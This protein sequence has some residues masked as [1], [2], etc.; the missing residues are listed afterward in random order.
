MRAGSHGRAHGVFARCAREQRKRACTKERNGVRARC[1]Y[2]QRERA[3]TE[4]RIACSCAART[5]SASGLVRKSG[6]ACSHAARASS[7]SGFA[8]NRNCSAPY[9]RRS[10]SALGWGTRIAPR[11]IGALRAFGLA[12]ANE[13]GSSCALVNWKSIEV[14]YRG[15][16]GAG[17]ILVPW[18]KRRRPAGWRAFSRF[19]WG[20]R[21]RT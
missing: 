20:T 21:I 3:W 7:A 16:S 13:F 4:E 14:A 11:A 6:T 19:G 10:G 2:E 15:P 9:K 1:A 8:R 17:D 12:R 5:S 18:P